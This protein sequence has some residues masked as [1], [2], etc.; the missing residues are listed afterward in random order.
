MPA[1]TVSSVLSGRPQGMDDRDDLAVARRTAWRAPRSVF[2]ARSPSA[3][4]ATVEMTGTTIV[5]A[6]IQD[7]DLAKWFHG[8]IERDRPVASDLR[9]DFVMAPDGKLMSIQVELMGG[10]L[11]TH[12]YVETDASRDKLVL[13]SRSD[14]VTAQG[15]TSVQIHWEVRVTAVDDGM[16]KLTNHVRSNASRAFMSFLER[17]DIEIDAFRS[18]RLP[19]P[20]L[21]ALATSI[22]RAAVGA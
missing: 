19:T 5:R 14:L 16:S 9:P 2:P 4:G 22:R 10:S 3:D 6:S 17:Q 8:S 12:Y 13:E 11:I 18:Q 20:D 15:P 21:G 1:N 7:I